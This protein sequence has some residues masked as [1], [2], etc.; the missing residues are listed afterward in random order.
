M[1][2]GAIQEAIVVALPNRVQISELLR[3]KDLHLMILRRK[4]RTT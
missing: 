4:Q 2:I 1:G 3:F